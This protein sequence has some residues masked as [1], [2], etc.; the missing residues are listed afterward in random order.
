M[1]VHSQ[2]NSIIDGSENVLNFPDKLFSEAAHA[3][4]KAT[5]RLQQQSNKYLA[6][7]KNKEKRLFARIYNRDSLQAKAVFGNIDSVYDFF[8]PFS[9]S[10]HA[11]NSGKL[12][13][14]YSGKLDSMQTAIGFL[15]NVP[16]L[17]VGTA[18]SYQKLKQHYS[19]L[20]NK[21]N[22][23]DYIDRL[24]QQRKQLLVN[25]FSNLGLT[26]QLQQ[27]KKQV[28]Y[29]QQELKA[30]KGA[31]ENPRLLEHKAL[32]VLSKVPAFRQ[33]FDKFSQLGGMFR[34][35]G[36]TADID[37]SELLNGLQVRQA[38]IDELSHLMGGMANTQ[39]AVTNGLQQGQEQLADLK[40]KLTSSLNNEEPLDMPGFKPNNQ[41]H[42]TF[43][44]RLQV[45]ANLQSLRSTTYF[46]T[47]S[48]LGFS[49]GYKMN[50][51]SVLG[52]GMSY[53][54]GW[55]QSIQAIRV[56]HEGVGLRSFLDWRIK[57]KFWASGGYEWNY[58]SRLE[59][60]N[61]IKAMHSWQQSAL[62]GLQVKQSIGKNNSTVSILYDVL[63]RRHVPQTQP[64]LFRVGYLLK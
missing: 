19:G 45:G 50:Q 56:T 38:V 42:K 41:K 32:Q 63:W 47:T 29:Y 7:L 13:L 17:P 6:R 21:L 33:Y 53:K 54:V 5:E 23:T 25:K 64:L 34:L 3:S 39:Q 48:D 52:A 27:Y 15:Q 58:R 16:N 61:I 26:K 11:L 55:G 37:P 22:Q 24:L 59:S 40:T 28:Y 46:P 9:F 31:L 30:Y 12:P 49:L 14:H 44:K 35:P 2:V 4:V 62:M 57:G 8:D 10:T 20:Q 36:Q 1:D 18:A 60:L 51:R 43:L